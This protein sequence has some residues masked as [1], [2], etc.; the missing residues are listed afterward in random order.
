MSITASY[1][2]IIKIQSVEYSTK[3]ITLQGIYA[4]TESGVVTKLNGI[5]G[6]LGTAI[7]FYE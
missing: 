2:Y 3:T 5:T 7:L 4:N 1:A 6:N